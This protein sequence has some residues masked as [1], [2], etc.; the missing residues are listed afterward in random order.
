LDIVSYPEIPPLQRAA[1]SNLTMNVSELALIGEKHFPSQAYCN[2]SSSTR[3][4]IPL[5][6]SNRPRYGWS[7]TEISA[8]LA[9]F[10]N[11]CAGYFFTGRGQAGAVVSDPT[12]GVFVSLVL[13][14]SSA[15]LRAI[16]L[17]DIMIYLSLG[18]S[19]PELERPP[20]F[21]Q[22]LGQISFDSLRGTYK[23]ATFGE[24]YV[25]TVG[26]RIEIRMANNEC[27][28]IEPSP[29]GGV[30]IQSNEMIPVGIFQTSRGEP[31]LFMGMQALK[32]ID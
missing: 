25:D 18:I 9:H 24:V 28:Y 26:E 3:V 5:T 10:A 32:K 27:I 1:V 21:E 16:V 4:H 17:R 15:S 29:D 7:I 31:G 13:N 12:N 14:V 22:F 30:A 11:G 2:L 6:V 23:G 8:G 20:S 19:D